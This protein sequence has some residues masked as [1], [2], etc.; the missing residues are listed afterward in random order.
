MPYC[1]RCGAQLQDYDRFCPK[2]GTPVITFT[3]APAPPPVP[4]ST[5]QKRLLKDPYVLAAIALVIIVVAAVLVV[6]FMFAPFSSWSAQQ[7]LQDNSA[8][9]NRVNFNFNTDVG[10]VNVVTQKIADNNLLL[11]VSANGSKGLSGGNIENPVTVTFE[12]KTVGDV[13]D[14]T[15]TVE[16][17]DTLSMGS[18]VVCDIYVDPALTLNL[19][20]SSATGQVSFAADKPT[21]VVNLNLHANTGEVQANLEKNVLVKGDLSL[22]TNTGAVHFRMNQNQVEGNCTLD[23]QSNTGS[24]YLDVAQTKTLQGNLL[25]NALT[26]TGSINV[27][28]NIDGGVAAKITSQTGSLGEVNVDAENFSGDKSPIQSNNYPADSNIEISNR[29]TGMGSVNINA[30][31]L[32]TVIQA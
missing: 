22:K 11:H 26:D 3:K 5:P 19:N 31:Y 2:C 25:V 6:A 24:V 28:L 4:Q 17:E 15:C 20:V 13:L 29:I 30:A 23:L 9:V 16:V 18:N 12:N 32:T 1:R 8:G 21:T 10:R 14:V 27:G 7:T